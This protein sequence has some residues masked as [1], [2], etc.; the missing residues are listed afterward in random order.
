MLSKVGPGS[1]SRSIAA[2]F[3]R[4]LV[5][6]ELFPV[7]IAVR[8]GTHTGNA[9]LEFSNRAPSRASRSRFGVGSS[10]LPAQ[11]I[12]SMR[13]WF[14]HDEKKIRGSLLAKG[15]DWSRGGCGKLASIEKWHIEVE[16]L[17]LDSTLKTTRSAL[18]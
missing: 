11:L 2:V 9:Q 16:V 1:L 18:L 4:T 3:P 17:P 6:A 12:A 7:R 14:G 15:Q 13:S 8:D 5:L 10:L